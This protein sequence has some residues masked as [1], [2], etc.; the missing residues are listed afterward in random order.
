MTRRVAPPLT[1]RDKAVPEGS[2]PP[3]KPHTKTT[4]G[5]SPW[6][7]IIVAACR[8][9]LIGAGSGPSGLPASEAGAVAGGRSAGEGSAVAG[10][11]GMRSWRCTPL[12]LHGAGEYG[13]AV[14]L[15]I[16]VG[17][18]ELARAATFGRNRARPRACAAQS[19][20]QSAPRTS[21]P[22]LRRRPPLR[23]PR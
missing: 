10:R 23:P 22:L 5:R 14:Y 21:Q 8:R 19:A 3:A 4:K 9:L 15:A 2:L 12:I 16:M 1:F 11:S 13:S 7:P 17:Y 18:R 20:A 6:R